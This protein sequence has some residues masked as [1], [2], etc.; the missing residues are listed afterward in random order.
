[1][2]M[3]SFFK[4]FIKHDYHLI[5]IYI[6][7]GYLVYMILSNIIKK[8]TSK[9]KTKRGATISTIIRHIIKYTIAII[10]VISILNVLG[11]NVTSMLAGVGI[12]GVVVG[13]SLQDIMK[14]YLVG[15]S[16]VFEE[17]YDVGDYVE[18]NGHSGIIKKL[19]L[20][21]T[22]LETFENVVITIPN[23]M[24]TEVTNYSKKNLNLIISIPMPYDVDTKK[25]DKVIQNIVKKLEKDEDVIGNID[26][27]E[28][29]SFEESYIKHKISMPVKNE[30]QFRARR[31]AN[32]TIKEEFDKA[33]I[34]IPFNIIEV[35]NG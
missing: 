26:I 10:V 11:I 17:Q 35:K 15:F 34:S 25:A 23:R 8:S 18:I 22:T 12:I 27:W 30:A 2:D 32:K 19:N 9:I 14:D 31:K 4:Y 29:S 1:M 5:I 6:V 21:T 24:I 28:F 20:K 33:G 16:I 7:L 3:S 13:L